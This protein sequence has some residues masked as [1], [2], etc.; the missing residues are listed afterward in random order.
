MAMTQAIGNHEM[1]L[2]KRTTIASITKIMPV[3]KHDPRMIGRRLNRS[4][5]HGEKAEAM[6]LTHP[7]PKAAHMAFVVLKPALSKID[8]E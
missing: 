4:I 6:K 1:A 3:K 7:A 2:L 5:I 8:T